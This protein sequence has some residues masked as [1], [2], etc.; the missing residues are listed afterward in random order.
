MEAMQELSEEGRT[1][2]QLLSTK[3]DDVMNSFM[4]L[5][6]ERD[7]K[8]DK[9][10]EEVST[11]KSKIEQVEEKMDD[12]DSQQRRNDVIVSGKV[13]PVVSE[14]ENC[15]KLI[16]G[17]F[18]EHVKVNLK[19]AD[20]IEAHRVGKKPSDPNEDTRNIIVR[21]SDNEIKHDLITA[22]KST[23]PDGFY[24]NENLIPKRNKFLYVLRQAKKKFPN[25]IAGCNSIDMKVF[26][27]IKPPNKDSRNQRMKICSAAKL[28]EFCDKVLKSS[29]TSIVGDV[30][31]L[32]FH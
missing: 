12:S 23:K 8:I 7:D 28:Q 11:L 13:L 4:K 19:M 27:W 30:E 21:V 31:K 1:I 17:L 26:V 29:L 10:Q 5:L 18:K 14:G 25:I 22:C 15:R 2:V 20:I 24:V 16:V 6:K 9:L 32:N 3:I